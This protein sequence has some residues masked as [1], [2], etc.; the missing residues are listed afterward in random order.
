MRIPFPR[1][2]KLRVMKRRAFLQMMAAAGPLMAQRNDKYGPVLQAGV[3]VWTQHYGRLGKRAQDNIPEIC[4]GF[5]KAGYKDVELMSLF[6]TPELEQITYGALRQSGLKCS[7]AYNGGPMH[8]TEGARTTVAA[9]VELGQRLQRNVGVKGISINPNPVSGREKTDDE[10]KIQAE[11]LNQLGWSLEKNGLGLYL[12]QHAPEMA[13][14]AREWRT[15]LKQT[16]PRYLKV[17]LDTHWVLRGG[18]DVMTLLKECGP[19]LGSVHLRNSVKGVWS[20]DFGDGDIDYRAVA[21]YLRQ[22]NFD[23]YLSVELAW[24]KETK[25]TRTLEENLERSRV[26]TAKIFGL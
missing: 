9:T 8:T 2:D 5:A 24:D 26:Y 18:Q 21:A 23:G 10:L 6:F 12:H 1:C 11:A 15:M 4:A 25:V 3:Y 22:M 19:R 14:G 7:V 13:N 20:E 17:C 16:E